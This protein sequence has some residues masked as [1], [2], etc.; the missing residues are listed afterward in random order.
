MDKVSLEGSGNGVGAVVEAPALG[1]RGVAV[2]R[3]HR[4]AIKVRS[5]IPPLV[6]A[7]MSVTVEFITPLV[8][9]RFGK[10]SRDSI[11][12]KQTGTGKV[13]A[14]QKRDPEAECR[15]A[16]Y[17]VNVK[18][19]IYG[20]LACWF[21]HAIVS[22]LQ[23]ID[24]GVLKRSDVQRALWVRGEVLPLVDAKGRPA[25]YVMREDMVRTQGRIKVAMPR[26]RPEFPVGT[27]VEVPILIRDIHMVDPTQVPALLDRAGMGGVGEGR[28][29]KCASLGWGQF[30]V[31]A[32]KTQGGGRGR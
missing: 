9:Q 19:R 26:W 3:T 21:K 27:R 15:D 10:K 17:V 1:K 14:R 13:S 8:I 31:I 20:A 12:E 25:K 30:R 29:Q 7:E 11:I 5:S 23:T 6:G 28:P 24:V 18:R 32:S 16:L 22:A 4:E 2:G